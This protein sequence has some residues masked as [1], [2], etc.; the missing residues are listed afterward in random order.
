VLIAAEIGRAG[1]GGLTAG[2]SN[3][4]PAEPGCGEGHLVDECVR[5]EGGVR[6]TAADHEDRQVTGWTEELGVLGLGDVLRS[7]MREEYADAS[8]EDSETSRPVFSA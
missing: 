6:I 8:D 5:G 3:G 1:A 2:D 7:T 4:K